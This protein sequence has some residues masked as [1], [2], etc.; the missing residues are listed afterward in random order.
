MRTYLDCIP[1]LV[2]QALEAVRTAIPD[3]DEQERLMRRVLTDL[4]HFSFAE[5]PPVMGTHIHRLVR[6]ETGC[7]DPYREAKQASNSLALE[8][9]AELGP[10]VESSADPFG[11]ALRLAVVANVIDLGAKAGHDASPTAVRAALRKAMHEQVAGDGPA[12]LR[13]ALEAADR[14]L[15]L[16]D[17]AGEIAFDRLLIGQMPP[18][19]VTVAVRG[20]PIINDATLDDARQVGIG[21]VARLTTT[22]AQVPGIILEQCSPEF[23][24]LFRDADVVIAKGQGN[25]ETLSEADRRIFFLLRTKCPVLARD[26]GRSV[27]ELVVMTQEERAVQMSEHGGGAA[28][29]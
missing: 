26:T 6:E 1:C 28:A 23:R 17:N 10:Q 9:V 5:P 3:A 20:G 29:Q 24:T 27:G 8:L 19:Q 11:A 14:V 2:R 16:T 4:A 15:Y 21:D 22:G 7:A 13:Q 25:Y 12:A 18:A